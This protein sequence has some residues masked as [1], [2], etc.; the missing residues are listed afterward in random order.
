MVSDPILS[1]SVPHHS[2]TRICALSDTALLK[3]LG[4]Q[5]LKQQTFSRISCVSREKA[6]WQANSI[7]HNDSSDGQRNLLPLDNPSPS[8]QRVAKSART[9]GIAMHVQKHSPRAHGP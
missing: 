6:L 7:I 1:I 5:V 8:L 9:G 4:K 2:V 3:F